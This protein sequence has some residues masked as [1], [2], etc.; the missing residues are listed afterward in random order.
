MNSKEI[1]VWMEKRWCD[2]LE[3]QHEK[4]LTALVED[5]LND[6]IPKLPEPVYTQI[7]QELALEEMKWKQEQE[8]GRQFA[9]FHV[10]QKE[11]HSYLQV[12]RKLEVLEAARLLRSYLRHGHYE[13]LFSETVQ[14]AEPISSALFEACVQERMENTGRVVGAF[15][16]NFDTRQFSALHIMNGWMVYQMKD[17]TAA[18]YHADRRAYLD[19]EKRWARFLEKL[20][21]KELHSEKP[22]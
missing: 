13:L 3:Q 19:H 22:M 9:V 14:G 18:A 21:G 12:E 17:V 2:A 4:P 1:T 7:K 6:L 10:I 16:L 5:Y 15:E 11:K 20:E 8:A